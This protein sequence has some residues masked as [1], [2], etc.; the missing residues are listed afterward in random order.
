MSGLSSLDETYREYSL[1]HADD[2]IRFWNL[3]VKGQGHRRLSKS[4]LVNTISHELLDET[5]G[6]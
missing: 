6:K 2:L 5:Y 4:N 3:E 1:S